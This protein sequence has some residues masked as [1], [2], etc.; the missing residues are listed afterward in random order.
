[1]SI[2]EERSPRITVVDGPTTDALVA[3]LSGSRDS[4]GRWYASR[5]A[6][7]VTLGEPDG[8]VHFPTV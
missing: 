4:T 6:F 8:C 5:L 3:A 1:M 2:V 7:S